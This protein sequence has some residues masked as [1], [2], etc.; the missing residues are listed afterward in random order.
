MFLLQ[1]ESMRIETITCL[2]FRLDDNL[3]KFRRNR[4]AVSEK[5]FTFRYSP[6]PKKVGAAAYDIPFDIAA[7]LRSVTICSNLAYDV[8]VDLVGSEEST[9]HQSQLENGWIDLNAI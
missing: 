6:T 2:R 8:T 1:I 5:L 4:H 9:V 7:A 3:T